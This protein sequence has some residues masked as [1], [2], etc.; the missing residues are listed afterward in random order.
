MGTVPRSSDSRAGPVD[1]F[2]QCVMCV[3][4]SRE[5][6]LGLCVVTGRHAHGS[7]CSHVD[8][9]AGRLSSALGWVR[10]AA[11]QQVIS[12]AECR[13]R[14]VHMQSDVREVRPRCWCMPH[15]RRRSHSSVGACD[16]SRRCSCRCTPR[17]SGLSSLFFCA[18]DRRDAGA[19]RG[20][21]ARGARAM[22][23]ASRFVPLLRYPLL[24]WP[25]GC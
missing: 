12:C 7:G 1:G 2:Q 14:G 17:R 11:W 3:C 22:T 18:P 23:R 13:E 15:A 5:V 6:Q 16:L 19:G 24:P 4:R 21:I 10:V 9:I 8:A 20:N 25:Y